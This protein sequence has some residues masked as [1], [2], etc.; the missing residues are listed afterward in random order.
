[1]KA[2]Q[3]TVRAASA[4]AAIGGLVLLASC[5]ATLETETETETADV[6]ASGV[7]TD[8]CPADVVIQAD[9]EPESEH[10]GIYELVGDDYVIDADSKSVTGTLMDGDEETGVNV[11]IRIGGSPVGYQPVQSLLYQDDDI[12]MGYGRVT[13]TIPAADTN[14]VVGI[15]STLEAS[16]YSIYWDPATYPDVESVADLKDYDVTILMGSDATVWQDYLLG[17]GVIEASQI[18]QSDAP[19]PA[20]FIAADGADAEAGFASAEPYLYEVEATEWGKPVEIGLI[21]D[22]GFPEYFQSMI[23]RSA[24]VTEQAECLTELVPILQ[25]AEVAYIE[26]PAATNEL[27]VEL[28]EEYDTGWIY[29]ADQAEWSIEK[30][31]ELGLV[32]N[33]A[34]GVLGGYD[35]E[36]V[37]ELIDLVGEY[38]DYDVS[39]ITPDTLVTNQFID[40]SIGLQG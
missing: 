8:I 23:V 39:E 13:E 40:T 7:L 17:T 11:E 16:P 3:R 6:A 26:D 34:E 38:T 4:V 2:Q 36:R 12:L 20:T 37:Q 28:V 21:H 15:M 14:A 18:D 1:M 30:Q 32:G 35:I 24:D 19:K 25:R 10:G 31:K 33:N 27:I 9:W 22:L 29:T 5:S